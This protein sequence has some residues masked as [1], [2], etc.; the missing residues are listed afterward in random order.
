MLAKADAA[1]VL[2]TNKLR[3]DTTVI[4]AN[5]GYPTDSGLLAKGVAKMAKLTHKLKS[6]GLATRTKTRDRTRSVRSRARDIGANLRRRTEEAKDEVKQINGDLARVARRAVR[7]A[8]NVVRNAS[9]QARRKNLSTRTK[10]IIGETEV[11]E[12]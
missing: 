9:R 4:E 1:K 12:K 10:A 11:M 6:Q 8:R 5:V 7:E 3:A 2:K